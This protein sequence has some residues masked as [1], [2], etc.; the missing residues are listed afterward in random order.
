MSYYRLAVLAP[1]DEA[2]AKLPAVLPGTIL[3]LSSPSSPPCFPGIAKELPEAMSYYRLTVLAPTDEAP[4][5]KL[6]ARPSPYISP[7]SSPSSPG[8]RKGASRGNE[9][10]PPQFSRPQTRPHPLFPA[11]HPLHPPVSRNS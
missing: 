9:S 2:F 8:Q 6:P 1:T 4:F 3:P 5:A 7:P 10:L 11:L